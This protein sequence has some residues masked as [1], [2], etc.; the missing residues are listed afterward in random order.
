MEEEGFRDYSLKG[1]WLK[2]EGLEEE[3]TL[4]MSFYILRA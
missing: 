2:Q 3:G 1:D 4:G